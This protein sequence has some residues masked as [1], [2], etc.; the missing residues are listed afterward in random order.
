MSNAIIFD[1]ESARFG[2]PLLFSGQTQKE[3]YV[4]EAHA[5]MDA[6]LHCAIEGVASSAPAGPVD[7]MNWLI[8][9]NAIGEWE[10]KSGSLACRQAGGWIYIAPR[11]GLQILNRATGQICRY[12]GGWQFPARMNAPTGGG[13]IDAEA[14]DAIGQLILALQ[15]LGFAQT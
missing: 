6:L 3:V 14:R 15:A 13:V 8:G 9:D 11:D 4:N 12:F 7:G 5:I 1:T 2:L 10:G